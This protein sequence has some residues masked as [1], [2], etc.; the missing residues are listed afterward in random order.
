MWVQGDK[1]LKWI[2]KQSLSD[3]IFKESKLSR[4]RSTLE[5]KME[6]PDVQV[7]ELVE[8]VVAEV[9]AEVEEE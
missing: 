2:D 9:E 6:N 4:D 7:E 8:V 5:N 3:L 1:T